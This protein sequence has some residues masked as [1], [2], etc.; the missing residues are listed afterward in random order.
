[1]RIGERKFSGR[2]TKE[3]VAFVNGKILIFPVLFWMLLFVADE[4]ASIKVTELCLDRLVC[5]LQVS[6]RIRLII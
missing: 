4:W 6:C 5:S 1:M 3:N 2:W